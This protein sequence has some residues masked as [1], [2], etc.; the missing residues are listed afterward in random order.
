MA[1]TASPVISGKNTKYN[2]NVVPDNYIESQR[3]SRLFLIT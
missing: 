3:P 1:Y 2:K